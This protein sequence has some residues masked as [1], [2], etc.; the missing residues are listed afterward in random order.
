MLHRLQTL[1]E[2]RQS[3]VSH[4]N[5]QGQHLGLQQRP[6]EDLLLLQA[7]LVEDYLLQ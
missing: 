5:H 1:V 4:P 6:P 7:E 2:Q 3:P